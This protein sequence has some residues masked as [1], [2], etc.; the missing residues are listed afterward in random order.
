MAEGPALDAFT[1][2]QRAGGGT[3]IPNLHAP[4]RMADDFSV[5]LGKAL[6]I[7]DHVIV[8]GTTEC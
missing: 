8:F 4:V 5:M 3:Q 2:H 7:H 6:V 1:I